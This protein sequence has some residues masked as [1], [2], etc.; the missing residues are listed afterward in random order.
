VFNA[1]NAA[2]KGKSL[3]DLIEYLMELIPG[4]KVTDRDANCG[5]EELDLVL[6][7]G[8][9]HPTLRPWDSIILVECK[10]WKGPVGVIEINWFLRKMEERGMTNGIFVAINGVTGNFNSDKGAKRLIINALAKKIRVIVVT[11]EDLK[12]LDGTDSL[13]ELLRNKYCKLF[14]GK[15]T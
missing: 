10:N 11:Q 5:D 2:E 1:S 9:V 14:L 7:N 3:E 6:W 15:V 8:Q 13:C 12:I 4:V